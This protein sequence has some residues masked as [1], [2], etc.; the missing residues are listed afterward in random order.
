MVKLNFYGEVV[1]QEEIVEI[2]I[3]GRGNSLSKDVEAGKSSPYSEHTGN[4]KWS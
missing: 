3:P 2:G 1:Y 4:V